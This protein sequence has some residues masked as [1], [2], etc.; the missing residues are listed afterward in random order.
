MVCWLESRSVATTLRIAIFSCEP[1]AIVEKPM[2]VYLWL[3]F[4]PTGDG[5]VGVGGRTSET[6]QVSAYAETMVVLS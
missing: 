5:S 2:W 4:D 3:T 1:P 6:D